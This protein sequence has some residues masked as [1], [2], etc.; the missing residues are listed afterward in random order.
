MSL[1]TIISEYLMN[2][3]DVFIA[4]NIKF[5]E[6]PE[7]M[8][9]FTNIKNMSLTYCGLKSLIN[10][11]PNLIKLDIKGN[12]IF[13]LSDTVLPHNIIELNV[14]NNKI[15]NINIQKLKKLK[16]LHMMYNPFT[17]NILLV[18]E[19]I[20]EINASNTNLLSTKCFSTLKNLKTLILNFTPIDSI[21]NLPDSIVD[22][23]VSR[24]KLGNNPDTHG[25]IFKLP[26]KI[27]KFVSHSSDIKGFAFDAFPKTLTY[28]DLYDNLLK[29]MPCLPDVMSYVDISKNILE[30]VAN[31]PQSIQNYD[32]NDNP[33]LKFTPEQSKILSNLDKIQGNTIILNTPDNDNDANNYNDEFSWLDSNNLDLF[34]HIKPLDNPIILNSR[35]TGTGGT[36]TNNDR[37]FAHL[38]DENRPRPIITANT[39]IDPSIKPSTEPSTEQVRSVQLG[40][41]YGCTIFDNQNRVRLNAPSISDAGELLRKQLFARNSEIPQIVQASREQK[42]NRPQYPQHILKLMRSDGFC[43]TKNPLRKISH[44]FIYEI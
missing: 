4:S 33:L 36:I 17:N 32:C 41:K 30:S 5:D 10:L 38:C 34:K 39:F 15:K 19:N 1:N 31:I 11:P 2:L 16:I 13:D 22:L 35:F 6:L 40:E 29:T 12:D 44:Q 3:S 9:T 20:E 23:S 8:K 14:S 24:T 25:T 43:A 42:I 21:E 28:L 18:P 27:M 37:G 7:I 26:K